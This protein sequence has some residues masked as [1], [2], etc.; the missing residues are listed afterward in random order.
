M[1]KRK[2]VAALPWR[3]RVRH[4]NPAEH[5][6]LLLCG[7]AAEDGLAKVALQNLSK[8]L[9]YFGTTLDRFGRSPTSGELVSFAPF[10]AR[11]I[12]ENGC[13]AILGRLDPFRILYLAEF[14]AQKEYVLEK[15]AKTAF[16]WFGD[17][18]TDGKTA[19][20]W[21]IDYDLPK[22]SRAM[23]SNHMDHLC[24]RP[25]AESAIDYFSANYP[26]H[27]VT[28]EIA[29]IDTDKFLLSTRG[30]LSRLYS[31][32]SKGVHWEF[33]NSASLDETT[34]R[35]SFRDACYQMATL[36]LFSHFIPTA[37]ANISK[38]QASE[39][40]IEYMGSII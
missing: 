4:G 12:L 10:C 36:G 21:D 14:Q 3:R 37:Y 38:T 27:P 23:L 15:R 6:A 7:R 34:V 1:P 9:V 2:E 22:I 16:S 31:T 19:A 13:A 30:I 5:L 17:V 28:A 39:S 20:L 29:S 33:F 8:T 25:A 32:L 11:V 40:Y 24:W 26:S 18:M 35:S